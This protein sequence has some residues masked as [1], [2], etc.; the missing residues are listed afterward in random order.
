MA[1]RSLFELGQREF[2]FVGVA[3]REVRDAVGDLA[4]AAARPVGAR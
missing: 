2:G 4:G 1:W 3:G